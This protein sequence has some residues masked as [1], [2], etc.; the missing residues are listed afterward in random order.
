MSADVLH[1]T[2][3]LRVLRYLDG[4]LVVN[5]E[6][7]SLDR[8]SHLSEEIAHP[9]SLLSGGDGR[10][11]LSFCSRK[12]LDGL[13]ATGP[14]DSSSSHLDNITAGRAF[15]I[16]LT[17]KVSVRE[18]REPGLGT[19]RSVGELEIHGASEVAHEMLDR[20]PVCHARI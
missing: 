11:V 18:G 6:R 7:T 1:A 16:M 19:V 9:E 12:R 2:M 10:D 3:V 4:G 20:F 13:Q 8:E 5:V 14:A 15:G 17:S